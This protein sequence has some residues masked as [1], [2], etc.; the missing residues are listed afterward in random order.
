MYLNRAKELLT[1]LNYIRPEHI[2][3]CSEAE[4]QSYETQL[5]LKLPLAYKEFLLWG[6]HGI[7]VGWNHIMR[8]SEF[9][10]DAFYY[11]DRRPYYRDLMKHD[12]LDYSVLDEQT[13]IIFSHH[14][15]QCAYIRAD[16]GENPPV[17]F[18]LEGES[19][20]VK[21]SDSYS[22][23]LE[24]V[25]RS[26][27]TYSKEEAASWVIPLDE[28]YK[29]EYPDY[30]IKRVGHYADK[31]VKIS[32]IPERVFDFVNIEYLDLRECGLQSL[33]PR[34]I[35]L[36]KLLELN[37]Q[38]NYLTTIIGTIHLLPNL[39]NCFIEGNPIPDSEIEQIRREFPDLK[40]RP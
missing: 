1:E 31:I 22:E 33:S 39:K 24:G 10:F 20:I 17:Y 4:V 35:E 14:D 27:A 5:G 32:N 16:E 30:L 9:Y 15:Y 11:D 21:E 7:G 40:L 38:Y 13:I 8:G 29:V 26:S 18:Y 36:P 3:P 34:I 25:I 23:Y 19:E 12:D 37:L 2:Y 6:G 28:V